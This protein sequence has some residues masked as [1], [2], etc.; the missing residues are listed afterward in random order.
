VFDLHC[1]LSS[2]RS[3][4]RVTFHSCLAVS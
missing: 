2:Y 4:H 3:V 1:S